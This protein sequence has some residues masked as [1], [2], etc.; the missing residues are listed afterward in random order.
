[1]DLGLLDFI[2]TGPKVPGINRK[3]TVKHTLVSG[4][5]ETRGIKPVTD[6]IY[7]RPDTDRA[8][9]DS[10]TKIAIRQFTGR[11]AIRVGVRY[12]GA[13]TT[14]NTDNFYHLNP[15]ESAPVGASGA[16]RIIFYDPTVTSSKVHSA[17]VAAP[18]LFGNSITAAVR[19]IRFGD[20]VKLLGD[21]LQHVHD[22]DIDEQMVLS[23][24]ADSLRI[25]NGQLETLVD[26]S[27]GARS[28]KESGVT[29][30]EYAEQTL[31]I[32]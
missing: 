13:L 6:G 21:T 15:D 26:I 24:I 5:T 28:I 14:P 8:D 23:G 3:A 12:D 25:S 2:A 1:M 7:V 4:N 11:S 32:G 9:V 20:A 17:E 19:T 22:G 31:R 18:E 27:S 30:R 29:M 10:I 16:D